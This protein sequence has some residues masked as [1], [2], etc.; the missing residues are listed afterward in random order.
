MGGSNGKLKSHTLADRFT[1]MSDADYAG[2]LASMRAIGQTDP[3][4]LLD[5]KILD[6]R[7][8]TAPASSWALPPKFDRVQPAQARQG[9]GRVRPGEEPT[10][11]AATG[12]RHGRRR[13][14]AT[15]WR[16][17]ERRGRGRKRSANLRSLTASPARSRLCVSACRRARSN[18]LAC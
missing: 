8:R 1:D 17:S 5:G 7:H 4:V 12:R 14:S 18:W 13:S 16:N 10:A 2:L 3:I 15:T 9:P 6:G 11:T